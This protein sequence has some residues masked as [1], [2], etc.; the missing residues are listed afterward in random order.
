MSAASSKGVAYP[1]TKKVEAKENLV[2]ISC[3]S[4]SHHGQGR[5]LRGRI[6]LNKGNPYPKNKRD[7]GW[8]TCTSSVNA[9]KV[10]AIAVPKGGYYE[11]SCLI[12]S[13]YI[14]PIQ[15]R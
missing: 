5:V 11:P 6:D 4:R 1:N 8:R 10:V 2:Q 3:I 9:A 7:D 15:A 14:L 13:S 12:D